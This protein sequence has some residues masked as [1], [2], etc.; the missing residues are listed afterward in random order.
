[1]EDL[2]QLSVSWKSRLIAQ[3]KT[4]ALQANVDLGEG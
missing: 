2:P 4:P 3:Q 1:M